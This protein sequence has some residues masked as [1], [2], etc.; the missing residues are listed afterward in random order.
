MVHGVTLDAVPKFWR[1]PTIM[2]EM[3]TVIWIFSSLG[4]SGVIWLVL[5]SAHQGCKILS[6]QGNLGIL[7]W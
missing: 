7:D 2:L 5:K 6:A 1:N 3:S 4:E